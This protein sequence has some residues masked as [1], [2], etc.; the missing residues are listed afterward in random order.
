MNMN[1]LRIFY[2]VAE[3]GSVCAGAKRQRI[4]QPAVPRQLKD[5]EAS[6]GTCVFDRLP[7]GVCTTATGAL[8]QDYAR[9]IFGLE[10]EAERAVHDVENLEAGELSIGASTTIG[11]YLLPPIITIF[12]ERYPSVALSAEIA[13]TERIEQ[14]LEAWTLALDFIEGPSNHPVLWAE[15]FLHEELVPVVNGQ[16]AL[17]CRRSLT[18]ADLTDVPFILRE[19]G[20]GTRHVVDARAS[21]RLHQSALCR[22]HWSHQSAGGGRGLRGL[23]SAA[24]HRSRVTPWNA[25]AP[26]LGRIGNLPAS[27]SNPTCRS[28]TLERRRSV[29]RVLD[30][31]GMKPKHYESLLSH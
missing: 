21:N 14:L 8:L 7:R 30:R 2:A 24:G 27:L 10:S 12:R 18:Y 11:N 29:Y 5:F 13:N 15:V 3:G 4:S 31:F 6:L 16:H 26:V 9:R 1:H 22:Q 17:A 23:A 25:R 28:P 19:S 20:S